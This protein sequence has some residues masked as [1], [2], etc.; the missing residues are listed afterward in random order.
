MT[1]FRSIGVAAALALQL[2][3]SGC[4]SAPD[5][6][7][8]PFYVAPR[9]DGPAATSAAPELGR[10]GGRMQGGTPSLQDGSGAD[11]TVPG[12]TIPGGAGPHGGGSM[13]VGGGGS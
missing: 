3:Q 9:Q 10:R 8:S 11:G 13:S 5:H 7:S 4:A 6:D 2:A 1:S 12:D